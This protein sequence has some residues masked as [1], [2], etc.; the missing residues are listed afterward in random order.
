MELRQTLIYKLT[1]KVPNSLICC[2]KGVV[3]GK[4]ETLEHAREL[5]QKYV[6]CRK[7]DLVVYDHAHVPQMTVYCHGQEIKMPNCSHDSA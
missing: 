7:T 6:S 2:D 5:T 1:I 3:H 4:A